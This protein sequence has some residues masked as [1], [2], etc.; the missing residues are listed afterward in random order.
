[1]HVDKVNLTSES[2]SLVSIGRITTPFVIGLFI[3]LRHTSKRDL[4]SSADS[5]VVLAY[6]CFCFQVLYVYGNAQ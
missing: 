1:M 3:F 4:K 5:V 6:I 2:E